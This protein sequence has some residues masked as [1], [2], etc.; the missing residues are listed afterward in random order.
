[1]DKKLLLNTVKK[2]MTVEESS[3]AALSNV[4]EWKKQRKKIVRSKSLQ[5]CFFTWTTNGSEGMASGANHSSERY[6]RD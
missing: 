5:P 2:K 3:A 1:M 4:E 6:H